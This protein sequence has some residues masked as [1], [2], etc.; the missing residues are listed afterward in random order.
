MR[1]VAEAAEVRAEAAAVGPREVGD[2]RRAARPGWPRGTREDVEQ[3]ADEPVGAPAPPGPVRATP[4]GPSRR[5]RSR[6]PRRAAG[7]RR[8][9]RPANGLPTA[10][11]RRQAIGGSTA[12]AATWRAASIGAASPRAGARSGGRDQRGRRRGG[13]PLQC[14]AAAVSGPASAARASRRTRA[15]PRG[16]PPSAKQASRSATSS[17]STAGSSAPSAAEQRADHA[18]VAGERE[19]RVGG[20]LGGELDRAGGDVRGRHDLADEAPAERLLARRSC[21]R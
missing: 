2:R 8:T 15:R 16:S 5:S 9:S 7:R 20:D 11:E 1:G 14:D 19:R 21:A 13:A 6:A 10:R 4:S 18:L 3:R 12:G 17:A